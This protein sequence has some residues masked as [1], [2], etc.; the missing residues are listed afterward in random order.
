MRKIIKYRVDIGET[1]NT[2]ISINLKI[3]EVTLNVNG[4]VLIKRQRLQSGLK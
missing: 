1:N 2:L 3:S 4:D